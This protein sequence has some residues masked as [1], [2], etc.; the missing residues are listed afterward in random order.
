MEYPV[1]LMW[2]SLGLIIVAFVM[3]F[4][5]G[6]SAFAVILC[7]AGIIIILLYSFGK[8][9]VS[10][11]PGGLEFDFH[12]NSPTGHQEKQ[13]THMHIKEVFH[14]DQTVSYD[15]AQA[16]C[17]AYNADLATFDQLQEAFSLGAEW[18]AYGWSAGGMALFPTQQSTWSQ[19]QQEIQETKRTAC[20]RPG[21]NGGYFD[22]AL[23]F[24]VN[25]Y[26][27][28]PKNNGMKFPQ[29]LPSQDPNYNKEVDKFKRML[30]MKLNGFNRDIWSEKKLGSQLEKDVG[31]I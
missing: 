1:I 7:V 25:C 28:K 10:I 20:G 15:E 12:E 29:P 2:S 31:L 14:V 6:T 18:C 11:G 23:K 8:F 22:P 21:V 26:G 9:D 17:G 27:E 16:V 30:P 19:L 13:S 4:L 3:L 5:V 24:G